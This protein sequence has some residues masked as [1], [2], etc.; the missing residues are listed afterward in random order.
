[1]PASGEP[2][3]RF[4]GYFA[5]FFFLAA[6]PVRAQPWE[7]APAPENLYRGEL[8]SYPGPW[9]FQIPPAGIILVSDEEL[10]ALSDPDRVLN[11]TTGRT[12]HNMSLRQVCERARARGQR[13]LSIAF[14]HFF[15]QYRPGQDTPRRLMPDM[16]EYIQRMA[17]IGRFARRYGLGLE[18]SLVTPLEI[19]PAYAA[20]TGESGVWLHYR[21]GLRDPQSGAFSVQ[22]WQQQRWANNKGVIEIQDAGVRVFAFRERPVP[23]TP[24][25]VVD[26]AQISELREHIQVEPYNALVSGPREYRARRVRV[27]SAGSGEAPGLDRV[28]VVQQYRTPEMDYFSAQALP[29]LTGLIDRYTAAGVRLNG[30]YSDEMHI[31]QD[32]SYFG[33]HDHGEFAL[34]YVSP[35]FA[36]QFA[37]RYGAEYRDFARYLVYFVHGQEDTANDLTA[38]LGGMH[39]FGASPEDIRRTALLRARYYHFLQ[40]GVVDLFVK[41][42]HYTEWKMGHKLEARAHATWAESPPIDAYDTGAPGH[43]QNQYE[44]TSAFLWSNTVQQAAAACYDYFKWGDFLTGNGNDHTEGGWLDRDYY[45]LALAASTGILN[46]VPYSYAAHWGMPEEVSRLRSALVDAYGVGASSPFQAVEGAQHRD[47]EVL[48]LYPLDLVAVEERFGSWMTQYGYA[49]YVT[50]AKLLE[51]GKVTRGAIEMAGRRFTTLVA[52]FEPFPSERLLD[53]MRQFAEQGGKLIWSGPPPLVTFEGS[54][55]L[56]AWE[57]IFG[58]NYTPQPRDGVPAPGELVTFQDSFA[59]VAPMVILTDFLVDRLYG[60][61]PRQGTE[62]VARV[63]NRVVGTRRAYASGGTAVFLGYRPRDDQSRSLGYETRNWFEVLEALGAYPAS[64]RF[65]GWNDNTERVSRDTGYLACR[66]PNGAVSLAPHLRTYEEG[67]PGGFARDRAADVAYL[68]RNPPPSGEIHLRDFRVAGHVVSYDGTGAVSFRLGKGGDL[69]AFAGS[70]SK[71]ITVDGLTAVFADHPL[72]GIAW[73]PVPPARR[74]PGGAV[75]VVWVSGEGH[76]WIPAAGLPRDFDLLAEG[77]A[78]GSRGASV[79][80]T[81]EGGSIVFAAPAGAQRWFYVVPK[82]K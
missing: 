70:G 75:F 44:Y 55:A 39:V 42:K 7:T 48:M 16:D 11:L 6:G 1:M 14:D 4:A 49:N 46:E 22:L 76:V 2:C 51:R 57:D 28:L 74:I 27:Y 37:G 73:S 65:P 45:A 72:T 15:A 64:G 77:P 35:G 24:Y 13:T 5:L 34:R 53:F 3:M 9:A 58:V 66:F 20:R 25:R 68:K 32:W 29:F 50:P 10:R 17:A 18:L 12:P 63:R 80:W 47:V 59:K 8:I 81:R 78:P 71:Q 67:W 56:E 23:G 33:H 79:A 19:G 61:A 41:A 38:K 82:T 54:R 26:P 31:Q 69:I 30:L 40:D 52:L 43:T 36:R 60:V 62:A 21:E